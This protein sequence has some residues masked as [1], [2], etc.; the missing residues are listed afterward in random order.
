MFLVLR[1]IYVASAI[2]AVTTF[3]ADRT[4]FPLSKFPSLAK[5]HAEL[6]RPK[7]EFSE[8]KK[9]FVEFG[10]E[11]ARLA[12]SLPSN[13]DDGAVEAA[14]PLLEMKSLLFDFSVDE[15]RQQ[16][17]GKSLRLILAHSG[18]EIASKREL[19]GASLFLYDLIE[20]NC[21]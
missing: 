6:I 14:L 13:M 11:T 15:L 8:R 21:H 2:G 9:L 1:F 18:R 12:D 4:E 16:D 10:R 7:V 20:Q 3:A 19:G 17:C 5:I